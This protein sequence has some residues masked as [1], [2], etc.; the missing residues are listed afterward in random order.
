MSGE[1]HLEIVSLLTLHPKDISEHAENTTKKEATL[2]QLS[3]IRLEGGSIQLGTDSPTPC[4]YEGYRHCET[5]VHVKE[6]EPFY[7]AQYKVTNAFFEHFYPH[8]VRPPQSQDDNTP[9]VEVKYGEANTFCKKLNGITHMN[10]RLPTEAEWCFAAAPF[11]Y[12]YPL[13]NTFKPEDYHTFGDGHEFGVAPT[14][15]NRWPANW[16]GLDQMGH[17]VREIIACHHIPEG[18]DGYG[19]DPMYCITKGSDYGHCTHAAKVASRTIFDVAERNPR[20]GFRLAH[21]SV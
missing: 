2:K 11:G 9:V 8:H 1:R 14:G 20:V 7:I 15:D 5:P 17:N 12:E 19:A 21:D 18:H 16:A 10:F 3:F 4:R 6:V 13:G